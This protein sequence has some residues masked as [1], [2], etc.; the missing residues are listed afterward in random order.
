MNE[1]DNMMNNDGDFVFVLKNK[2]FVMSAWC[3]CILSNS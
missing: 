3:V 2:H 1:L